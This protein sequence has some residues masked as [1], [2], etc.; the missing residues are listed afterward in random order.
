MSFD[1]APPWTNP[2]LRWHLADVPF[3]GGHITQI[4]HLLEAVNLR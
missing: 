3:Y 4:L 1:L 2:P